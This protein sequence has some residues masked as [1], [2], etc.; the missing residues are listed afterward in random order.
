MNDSSSSSSGGP[1]AAQPQVRPVFLFFLPPPPTVWV[2]FADGVQLGFTPSPAAYLSS[3]LGG[4]APF[5]GMGAG[6]GGAA[7]DPMLRA[8]HELFVRSQQQ[9][10][11]PPPTSKP[12]LDSLPVKTW[13]AAMNDS[14]KHCDCAICLCDY[15]KDDRVMTLPCGHAFHKDCG[16]PWL[17][18][19]NV[20]PTCR[21]QLPTQQTEDQTT[22]TQTQTQTEPETEPDHEPEAESDASIRTAGVRRPRSPSTGAQERVVR[23]RVDESATSLPGAVAEDKVDLDSMLEQE[24]TQFVEDERRHLSQSADSVDFDD[25]DVEELLHDTHSGSN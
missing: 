18:E 7:A 11:G 12:F 16:T 9:Q 14:E 5:P 2:Q 13:T 23:Q 4:A 25:V 3:V 21:Y 15:E 24:A 19:H 20:C 8:L 22:Q 10:H 17:V 6:A 1:T